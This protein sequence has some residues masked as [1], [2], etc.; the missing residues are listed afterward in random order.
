MLAHPHRRSDCLAARPGAFGAADSIGARTHPQKRSNPAEIKAS[1]VADVV[2]IANSEPRTGAAGSSICAGRDQR[3]TPAL[4]PR[5]LDPPGSCRQPRYPQRGLTPG[6]AID[7]SFV[8]GGLALLA[9]LAAAG[10]Q[11]GAAGGEKQTTAQGPDA[12]DVDSGGGQHQPDCG[13][14]R[15]AGALT[16]RWDARGCRRCSASVPWLA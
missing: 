6:V 8:W 12:G 2:V 16:G 15:G 5:F 14:A 4:N 3:S 9:G 7:L 10:E 13:A 11:Q 1:K